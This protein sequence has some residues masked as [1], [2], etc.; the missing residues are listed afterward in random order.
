MNRAIVVT[1]LALLAGVNWAKEN[2]LISGMGD[3]TINPQGE[4]TR[5]QVAAIIQRFVS[6]RQ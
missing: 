2:G 4:A 1:V 5:A 6:N 3:G